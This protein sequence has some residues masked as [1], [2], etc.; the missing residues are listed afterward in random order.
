MGGLYIPFI[1]RDQFYYMMIKRQW[2]YITLK[3]DTE[4]HGSVSI[5]RCGLRDES[6]EDFLSHVPKDEPRW[7]LFDFE[8]EAKEY[9]QVATKSKVILIVYSPDSCTDNKSKTIITFK[10]DLLLKKITEKTIINKNLQEYKSNKHSDLEFNAIKL[11]L[12]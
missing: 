8:W 12:K 2:R 3:V 6:H 5:E 10:K 7:I 11:K 9:G 4:D 1:C